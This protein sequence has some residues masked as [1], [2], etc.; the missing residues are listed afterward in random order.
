MASLSKHRKTLLI[1]A[2]AEPK[3]A[4]K[5]LAKADGSLIS[6][7]SEISLNILNG[8]IPLTPT[9]KKSLGKYKGNLRTMV[10]RA[11]LPTKRKT[12]Q[13]GGFLGTLLTAVAPL[14]FKGVVSLVSLA[15]KKAAQ[16]RLAR[17]N[18]RR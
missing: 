4:R 6:A 14:I 13:T 2:R 9:R 17:K 1:L 3:A 7:L 11:G 15:K 8:L 10:G 16:K 12:L 18:R 5:I